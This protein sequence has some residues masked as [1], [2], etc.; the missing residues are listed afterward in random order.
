MT[1][2]DQRPSDGGRRAEG[3]PFFRD[4]QKLPLRATLLPCEMRRKSQL[5]S[6][7]VT[8]LAKPWRDPLFVRLHEPYADEGVP[9]VKVYSALDEPP[10][11][12]LA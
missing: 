4:C 1:P 11:R 2:R 8:H 7:F 3:R 12:G 5:L 9:L 6:A 10:N